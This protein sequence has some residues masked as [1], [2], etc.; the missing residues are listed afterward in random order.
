MSRGIFRHWD[1]PVDAEGVPD[2]HAPRHAVVDGVALGGGAAQVAVRVRGAV[3][4]DLK[5]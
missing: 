4:G 3:D 2:D 1:G 5:E